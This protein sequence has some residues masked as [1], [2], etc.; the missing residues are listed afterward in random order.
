[1][2]ASKFAIISLLCVIFAILSIYVGFFEKYSGGIETGPLICVV[3]KRLIRKDHQN[4][5]FEG[6][7]SLFCAGD[8]CDEYFL[9]YNNSITELQA[10][11][12]ISSGVFFDSVYV[13]K[14]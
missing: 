12:G 9:Q 4:C 7:A 8:D 11:P 3:G 1:M 10:F 2:I 13:I 5:T 14:F 6:L